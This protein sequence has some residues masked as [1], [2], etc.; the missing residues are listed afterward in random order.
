[1]PAFKTP[2]SAHPDFALPNVKPKGPVKIDWTNRFA[3]GL[4]FYDLLRPNTPSDL[5]SLRLAPLVRGTGLFPGT[6]AASYEITEGVQMVK[7]VAAGGSRADLSPEITFTNDEPWTIVLR[8]K[9]AGNDNKGMLIGDAPATTPYIWATSGTN[10]VVNAQAASTTF[11]AS[12]NSFLDMTDFIVTSTGEGASSSTL[13]AYKDGAKESAGSKSTGITLSTLL[14]GHSNSALAFSGHMEAAAVYN[15]AWSDEDVDA[16]RKDR[17]QVLEPLIPL[18]VMT[19]ELAGG[20]SA[21]LSGTAT[22]STTEADIRTGAKTIILTLTGDTFVDTTGSKDGIVAGLDSDLSGAAGWDAVVKAGLDNTNVAFSVGDTVATITLPAFGSYDLTTAGNETITATIPAASLTTSATEVI[23]TPTFTVAPIVPTQ[24]ISGTITSATDEDDITTGGQVLDITL[25]NATW[26]AAADGPIGTTANTQAIIDG[27]DSAQ[28]EAAGWDA[29]VKAG[30]VPADDVTRVSATVCRITLPAFGSYSITANETI[31]VIVPAEALSDWDDAIDDTQTFEVTNAVGRTIT[32]TQQTEGHIFQRDAATGTQDITV[33]GTYTGAISTVEAQIVLDGTST[34]VVAWVTLDAAPAGGTFTGTITVPNGLWYNVDVRMA[35]DPAQISAG[36]TAFSVG[37]R[38]AS[39]GQSLGSR[40]F[41]DGSAQSP[42]DAI[43]KYNESGFAVLGAAS[44]GA[45]SFG[46]N[47]LAGLTVPMT[48]CLFDYATSASSVGSWAAPGNTDYITARDGILAVD[49]TGLEGV[50]WSQGES[51][52]LTGQP[53]ATHEAALLLVVAQCQA[54]FVNGSDET[55]LPFIISELGRR[56]GGVDAD[57]QAIRNAHNNVAAAG[58]DTYIGATKMDL[59]LVDTVHL[60]PAAFT[61]EAQR[62]ALCGLFILGFES[63]YLGPVVASYVTNSTT[64]TEI[65]LTHSAGSDFTPTSA[66]DGFAV[67]DDGTPVAISAA[68]RT[69]ATTITLTHAAVTGAKVVRYH[70]GANP[71]VTGPVL[72]N[73]DMTLPLKQIAEVPILVV[74]GGG[75]LIN[76]G[77]V[78]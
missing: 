68:V 3:K 61:I 28:V 31:T 52:A 29:V 30:L 32:Q 65:N 48:I 24:A 66:I 56:D 27:L 39:M 12:N 22:S 55:N 40:W 41:T 72:D 5:T 36:T 9:Q 11:F 64:E 44:N 57:V 51:D 63:Y 34:E 78:S 20:A 73:T 33:A 47:L 38:Y 69:D 14:R 58:A 13:T 19:P 43:R 37:R 67:E 23:A 74:S 54:D 71:A 25:T 60:T 6:T 75:R 45:T 26:K 10:I 70:Y 42:D 8:F 21:A 1:M 59:A 7:G 15:R 2:K 76:G 50:L 53:E 16:Y 77:L 18:L 4:L 46:N 35:N 62:M 49:D 17:Y